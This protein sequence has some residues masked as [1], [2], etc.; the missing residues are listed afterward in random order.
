MGTDFYNDR[1][2]PFAGILIKI[3]RAYTHTQEEFEDFYQ[4][5]C[6]QIWRSRNGFKGDSDWSTWIYRI[7][8]N[9]CMTQMRKRDN[10]NRVKDSEETLPETATMP[11]AFMNDEINA[12]YGAIR[13]LTDADRAVILL[14]LEEKSHREI[15][16][17]TGTNANNI[18]VRVNRIKAKLQK[19]LEVDNHG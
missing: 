5:A 6:L 3:C 8:L 19:I 17:I 15:A 14:Y 18:G 10:E 16:D 11:D 2:L 12:L 1:I 4:E 9:V 7:T 13:Q